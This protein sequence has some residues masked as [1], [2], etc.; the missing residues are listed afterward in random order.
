MAGTQGSRC[1]LT[2]L[3]TAQTEIEVMSHKHVEVNLKL[4][5]CLAKH[6]E[7]ARV[8]FCERSCVTAPR[9][10]ASEHSDAILVAVLSF[11][12]P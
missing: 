8:I 3:L 10:D 5:P 2:S 11:F 4:R 7:V 9:L 6:G 12:K 1:S